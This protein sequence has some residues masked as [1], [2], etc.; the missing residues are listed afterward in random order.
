MAW[1][2]F[3]ASVLW[4]VE[5]CKAL[6]FKNPWK[7]R[8]GLGQQCGDFASYAPRFEVKLYSVF[9]RLS[10]HNGLLLVNPFCCV[11]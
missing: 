7:R 9:S 5:E 10:G 2:K 6:K 3:I 4:L 8:Q 1:R 11:Q